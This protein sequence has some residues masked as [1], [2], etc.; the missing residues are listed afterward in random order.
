MPTPA[1]ASSR[2]K[3]AA[4]AA[5]DGGPAW[6]PVKTAIGVGSGET[7]PSAA[8]VAEDPFG[9]ADRLVATLALDARGEGQLQPAGK[10]R[11]VGEPRG[12]PELRADRDRRGEPHLVQ[13]VVDTHRGVAHDQHLRDQRDQQRQ[14]QVP[15]RDRPPERALR[16]GALD[17]DVDPLVVVGRV[18]EQVH[19]LLGDLVPV[20]RAQLGAGQPRQLGH[21]RGRGHRGRSSGTDGAVPVA[22]RDPAS[23]PLLPLPDPGRR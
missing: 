7:R 12:E 11:D 4:A 15:V 8:V 10:R 3:V 16:L 14:G 9:D 17:V 6:D 18:G 13:A 21:G 22:V 23:R 5:C 19:V 1:S 2:A 20:A